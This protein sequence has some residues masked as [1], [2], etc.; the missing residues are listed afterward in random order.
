MADRNEQVMEMVRRELDENPEIAMDVLFDKATEIDPAVAQMSRR[1]F[2][3]RYPLQIKRAR[4]RGDQ[5]E[6]PAAAERTSKGRPRTTT[7]PS[8]MARSAS[9]RAGRE[10]SDRD[11][12]RSVFMEFAS[13]FAQAE[14]RSEIVRVMGSIDDYVDRVQKLVGGR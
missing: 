7:S 4:G 14:S 13:D 6:Q 12:I 10:G 9:R 3:A 2:H 5:Q 8:R 11:A 1:Q